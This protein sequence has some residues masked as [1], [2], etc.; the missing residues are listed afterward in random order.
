MSELFNG[1][2]D[3]GISAMDVKDFLICMGASLFIGVFLAWIYTIKNKYSQSFILTLALIPVAVCVVIMTVNGNIGAGIAVAGAFG[4]VRFRSAQGSAKEICAI[5]L[6]MGVGLMTGMGYLG[7]AA[8]FALVT[9]I[10]FLAFNLFGI[11]NKKKA[12]YK[13]L[14]I[15]IPENL[16]FESVFDDVLKEYTSLYKLEKVKTTNMGSM[17]KLTYNIV[18]KNPGRVKEFIDA[19][20]CR[21]GNLEIALGEYD[22]KNETIL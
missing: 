4:L 18:F 13:T 17:Y 5:F 21:N 20:R 9:G 3:S 12:M 11:G 2:F 16:E 15:T 8:I 10:V 22:E 19:L 6:A 7:F 1:V 14:R